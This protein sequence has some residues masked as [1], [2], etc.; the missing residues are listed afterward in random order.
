MPALNG[1]GAEPGSLIT[2]QMDSGSNPESI[3][4]VRWHIRSGFNLMIAKTAR[5]GYIVRVCFKPCTPTIADR[6]IGS[7]GETVTMRILIVDD[8]GFA[9]KTI[10]A[11]MRTVFPEAAYLPAGNGR[12]GVTLFMEQDKKG[13]RPDIV[14]LDHLMPEMDGLEALERILE[15]DP[16]AFVVFVSANIQDP[17]QQRALDAGARLFLNKPLK[18]GDL[19]RLKS[20]WEEGAA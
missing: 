10:R 20:V 9:R 13:E 17:I 15:Y 2:V 3:C 11:G 18:S 16:S 14:L 7:G 12:E 19:K 1:V 5:F 6:V 4:T 8:S